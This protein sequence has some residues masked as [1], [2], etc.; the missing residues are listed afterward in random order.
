MDRFQYSIMDLID[1]NKDSLMDKN[2][3]YGY[4]SYNKDFTEFSSGIILFCNIH[5]KNLG[6]FQI[7]GDY[8]KYEII[9]Y[10]IFPIDL[11]WEMKKLFRE[12]SRKGNLKPRDDQI[13]IGD[14][15]KHYTKFYDMLEHDDTTIDTS[16]TDENMITGKLNAVP[17]KRMYN[18]LKIESI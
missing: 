17:L 7:L 5:I 18:D 8:L 9:F 12:K 1:D 11:I 15:P 16:Y 13:R 14:I 4:N 2:N 10:P 3:I 6:V